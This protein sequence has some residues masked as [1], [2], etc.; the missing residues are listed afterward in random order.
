MKKESGGFQSANVLSNEHTMRESRTLKKRLTQR[1][2]SRRDLK[3][4][5]VRV[6]GSGFRSL[7]GSR[8]HR[9][10]AAKTT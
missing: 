4:G 5:Q 8:V 9:R 3:P 2:G 6:L 10:Y 7:R 1:G